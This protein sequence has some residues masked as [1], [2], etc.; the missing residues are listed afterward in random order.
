MTTED[1]IFDI[2]N[3]EE[4]QVTPPAPSS[5]ILVVP[6]MQGKVIMWVTHT[7]TEVK[8]Y[9]DG[10]KYQNSQTWL[11]G[12]QE[13]KKKAPKNKIGGYKKEKGVVEL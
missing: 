10:R 8:I 12:P 6:A 11:E 3:T 9:P 4:G 1:F 2:S 13:Y 7:R 5:N